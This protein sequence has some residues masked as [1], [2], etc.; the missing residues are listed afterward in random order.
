MEHVLFNVRT[1]CHAHPVLSVVSRH[2]EP[3]FLLIS[4]CLEIVAHARGLSGH[5]VLITAP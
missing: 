2:P 5:S 1:L 4:D 3:W